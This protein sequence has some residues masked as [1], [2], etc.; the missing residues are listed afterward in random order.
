MVPRST[1]DPNLV[2]DVDPVARV[3][4][5]R[6]AISRHDQLY[7]EL[8]APEIPDADYDSLVRELGR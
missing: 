6:E 8:D 1:P 5:L 7:Y 3:E 2:G 4:Q